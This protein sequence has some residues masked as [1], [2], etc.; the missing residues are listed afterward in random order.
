MKLKSY[1]RGIGIGII[2]TSAVFLVSGMNHKNKTMSD[3][4]VIARAKELG[5]VE[6]TTLAEYNA[7]DDEID[8]EVAAIDTPEISDENDAAIEAEGSTDVVATEGDSST[9]VVATE[10][11]SSTDV[12]SPEADGSADAAVTGVDGAD[13]SETEGKADVDES[14]DEDTAIGSGAGNLLDEAEEVVDTK[15][16]EKPAAGSSSL[17]DADAEDVVIV[18]NSGDGSDKVAKKLFD[19]GLVPN[20][21]EFDQFLMANGYDRKITTGNHIISRMATGDEIGRNLVSPTK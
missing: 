2:V 9:D 15:T 13:V 1:I 6:S 14:V 18:V 3:A 12:V 21:Y 19:A 16:E 5:Y 7:S 8:A 20:A 10:G 11:D 4:E 17:E